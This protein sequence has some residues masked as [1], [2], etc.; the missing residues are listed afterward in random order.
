MKVEITAVH[1]HDGHASIS[2]TLIGMKGECN[3]HAKTPGIPNWSGMDFT[4]E[5]VE[6]LD[7]R[8]LESP[9]LIF[10]AVKF[11]DVEE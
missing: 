1:A 11:K 10:F 4:P 3:W 6:H 9:S 2:R 5:G 8:L 7:G